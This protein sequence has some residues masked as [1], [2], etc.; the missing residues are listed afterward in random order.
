MSTILANQRAFLAL[1]R[2]AEG[3]D[4]EPDPYRVCYGYRH[5]ID[6]LADH[7]AIT[8]EWKGE[9]LPDELCLKAGKAPGCVSTAA[10]AYQLI[11]PTWQGIKTRLRLR[12]F[13]PDSQD[14]A[15]LYLIDNRGALE[16]VHAGRLQDAITKCR[17]EWASLPGAGYGQPERRISALVAAF[18]KA[19]GTV[20]A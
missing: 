16:D 6:S 1:I 18:Q 12:D 15:A 7:P 8:G 4:R 14:R 19:G 9:K 20:M 10:G 17:Q 11:R 3:T 13:S 5:T 2:F